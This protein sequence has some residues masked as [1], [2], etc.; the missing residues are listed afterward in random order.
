MHHKGKTD[1][2]FGS[3]KNGDENYEG[4]SL[5]SLIGKLH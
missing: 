4:N 5:A 2:N 3:A 1:E